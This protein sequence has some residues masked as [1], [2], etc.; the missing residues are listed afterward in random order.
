MTDITYKSLHDIQSIYEV[1]S[2]AVSFIARQE[3]IN[4][5]WR[6]SAPWPGLDR[7]IVGKTR[8]EVVDK[9]F[10]EYQL[11]VNTGRIIPPQ[12]RGTRDRLAGHKA[13][14]EVTYDP[15]GNSWWVTCECGDFA[16]GT[17]SRSEARHEHWTHRESVRRLD[18][19]KPTC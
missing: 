10:F 13:T 12:P 9:Y 18:P 15:E 14:Y 2:G 3:Y 16:E 6:W 7:L 1:S 4:G 19:S 5:G 17:S 11:G 8:K